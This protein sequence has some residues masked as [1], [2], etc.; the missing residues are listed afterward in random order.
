MVSRGGSAPD[1][2][3]SSQQRS[4]S[5]ARPPRPRSPS[6]QRAQSAPPPPGIE[7]HNKRHENTRG[8]DGTC[9]FQR[10]S[11]NIKDV[12]EEICSPLESRDRQD[13]HHTAIRNLVD[14][15]LP[16]PK[17]ERAL[18]SKST[19]WI[20][21]RFAE[22]FHEYFLFNQALRNTDSIYKH[23]LPMWLYAIMRKDV[24]HIA[25]T[26]GDSSDGQSITYTQYMWQ[27]PWHRGIRS[28]AGLQKDISYQLHEFAHFPIRL[29]VDRSCTGCL[30]IQGEQHGIPWLRMAFAFQR[31]MRFLSGHDLIKQHRL[32]GYFQNINLDISHNVV[33]DIVGKNDDRIQWPDTYFNRQDVQQELTRL[34]LKRTLKKQKA[35]QRWKWFTA[36]IIA[37]GILLVIGVVIV[38]LVFHFV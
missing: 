29:W 34:R 26:T 18:Q 8:G 37:Y 5:T 30:K 1:R 33:M 9:H 22:F 4:R 10:Q 15:R 7:F 17:D 12:I 14:K 19:E 28:L 2:P 11:H 23:R 32:E 27:R 36:L 3:G 21:R 16:E 35:A 6:R 38:V 13:R 20:L 31:E 25:A 24:K